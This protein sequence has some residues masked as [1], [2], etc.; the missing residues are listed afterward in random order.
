MNSIWRILL[1]LIVPPL[2]VM[3]RGCGATLLV[4]MLTMIGWVPG[5]IAAFIM[6]MMDTP[7]RHTRFVEVPIANWDDV[8]EGDEKPKRDFATQEKAKRK[9]AVI[10]LADGDVLQVV[11]D[12]GSDLADLLDDY[13]QE[14]QEE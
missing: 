2:T 5:V 1:T 8:W 9:G 11:E 4:L 7:R 12:T 3:D 13:Q 6:Q 14:A 10:R